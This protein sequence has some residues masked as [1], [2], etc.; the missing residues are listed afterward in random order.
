MVHFAKQSKSFSVFADRLRLET[1]SPA[2]EQKQQVVQQVK[3][4]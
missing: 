4:T 2:L 1:I 3:I